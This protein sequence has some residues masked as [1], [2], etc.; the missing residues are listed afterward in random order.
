M[1]KV[2]E[3]DGV[4][5]VPRGELP[6]RGRSAGARTSRDLPRGDPEPRSRTQP[7][8]STAPCDHVLDTDATTPSV[9]GA[10]GSDCRPTAG[11]SSCRALRRARG[12][13]RDGLR[14]G[15]GDSGGPDRPGLLPAD[16]RAHSR[17]RSR[18]CAGRGLSRRP[19]N[20]EDEDATEDEVGD[21]DLGQH[22]GLVLVVIVAVS[23]CCCSA[24]RWARSSPSIAVPGA[25]LIAAQPRHASCRTS[26]SASLVPAGSVPAVRRP[27]L[28]RRAA[29]AASCRALIEAGGQAND[30]DVFDDLAQGIVAVADTDA[31]CCYSRPAS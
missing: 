14:P 17:W 30:M 3:T 5:G 20:D 4:A 27:L 26:P 28:E 18:S 8:A 11:R 29:R 21:A 7:D 31:I 9:P 6:H 24:S 19:V 1:K 23:S 22:R 10:G 25:M 13:H 2:V 12:L 16:H 15:A